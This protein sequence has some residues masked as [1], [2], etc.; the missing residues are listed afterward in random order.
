MATVTDPALG[1]VTL[2]SRPTCGLDTLTISWRLV[3][4]SPTAASLAGVGI[5]TTAVNTPHIVCATGGCDFVH[6][7]KL[8]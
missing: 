3:A 1:T 2:P 4:N 7:A 5:K 6:A 8:D